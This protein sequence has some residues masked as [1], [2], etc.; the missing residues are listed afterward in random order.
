[1]TYGA[2]P[3]NSW[4]ASGI[5]SLVRRRKSRLGL[6]GLAVLACLAAAVFLLV[7]QRSRHARAP[8]PL[9]RDCKLGPTTAGIDVSYYQGD[10][11]WSRVRRAGVQFAFIRA[12]DGID[13]FDSK[14]VTNWAGAKRAGVLRG[15]YQFFRPELS[16]IDQA[17][18]MIR[19]LKMYGAGE[20]PPVLDVETTGGQSLD[21]VAQRSKVWVDRVRSQLGVEP[22]VYTSPGMWRWRGLAEVAT[23]PLWLAHYTAQCPELAKPWSRWTFWQYTDSGRVPGIT[24]PVDLDVFDGPPA[25]LRRRFGAR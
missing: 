24:G 4:Q 13:V 9:P 21:I 5:S 25:E 7:R 23:Q 10:I 2:M 14:F 19:V 15:A 22:I 6:L 12:Y 20:L 17:D 18:N 8:L 16:P 3:P 11:V 1:M